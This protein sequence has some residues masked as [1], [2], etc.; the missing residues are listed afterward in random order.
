[1]RSDECMV[2]V[3]GGRLISKLLKTGLQQIL[4]SY[5][6]ES[7]SYYLVLEKTKW[8]AGGTGE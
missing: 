6:T 2:T 3:R 7:P 8:I 1:M 5:C 4:K